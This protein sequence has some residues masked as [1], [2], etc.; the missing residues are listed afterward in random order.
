MGKYGIKCYFRKISVH[1]ITQNGLD[2][3]KVKNTSN[4]LHCYPQA[5]NFVRFAL[6]YFVLCI[7]EVIEF[8]YGIMIFCYFE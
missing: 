5:Q 7:I 6:Q 8:L 2:I 1:L 4:E 3:P